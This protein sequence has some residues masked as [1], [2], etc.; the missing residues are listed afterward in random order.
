ML[1]YLVVGSRFDCE[2]RVFGSVV[3]WVGRLSRV[4]SASAVVRFFGV[5][6]VFCSCVSCC[7]FG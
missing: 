5:V 4:S 2:M 1:G 3:V 6:V 7:V